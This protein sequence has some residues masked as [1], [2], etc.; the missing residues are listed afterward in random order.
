[1]FIRRLSTRMLKAC[2]QKLLKSALALALTVVA[3]SVAA[4]PIEVIS[5][6]I[7]LNRENTDADKV[8]PFKYLGGVNLTST[9]RRF[10]GFSG[11]GISA[12]GRRMV[13][14]SD[15]GAFLS[16][17]IR[18][19][20][21]GKLTGIENADLGGLSDLDGTP[22]AAKRF[23]DA[24]SMS[25]GVDSEIII[26]FERAHRIWRYDPGVTTPRVLRPPAEL[27]GLR[28]NAGIEA[29]TLLNDGRLLAI[30]EGNTYEDEAITWVSRPDGWDAMT[31]R[32]HDGF[33]PTGAATL[34]GG[35]VLVLERY[36]TVREGVRIRIRRLPA[37]MVEAGATLEARLLVDLAPPLSVDNFEGIEVRADGDRAIVYLIS[38][39]NFNMLQRT[40]FLMFAYEG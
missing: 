20:P 18:Y 6:P 31:Y 1:M 3:S 27:E 2:M 26:S 33:R 23:S 4:E 13:S 11:L 29:L 38:D 30:S 16:A 9:D 35:D 10:G 7:P 28:S 25:P 32:T 21:D 8:G 34:P 40:L 37:G 22:L 12:D 14:I 19:G 5:D 36:F 24:E 39:D 17:D 15:Q